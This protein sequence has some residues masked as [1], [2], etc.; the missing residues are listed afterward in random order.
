MDTE[1]Y[2]KLLAKHAPGRVANPRQIGLS[3]DEKQFVVWFPYDVDIIHDLK[4]H[5]PLRIWSKENHCWQVAAGTANLPHLI[6]LAEKWNFMFRRNAYEV[7]EQMLESIAVLSEGSAALDAEVNV[8]GWNPKYPLHTFQKA[9]VVYASRAQRCIIGDEMG[10]GKTPQALATLE[11]L[12]AYPAVVVCMSSVKYQWQDEVQKF[13]PGRT[14]EVISSKE[15]PTY[16]AD[17]EIINYDILKLPREWYDDKLR[18]PPAVRYNVDYF[19][20]LRGRQNQAIVFD[21]IHLAKSH[22]SQRG[23]ACL[24]LARDVPIKLGLTGTAIENRPAELLQPLKI[25]GRLEDMGGFWYFVNAWCNAEQTGYGLNI[26]GS[27]NLKTLNERLRACCYIRRDKRDVMTEIPRMQPVK[28]RVPIT[29]GAAYDRAESHFL[30]YLAEYEDDDGRDLVQQFA[31]MEKLRQLA[32]RGKLKAIEEWIRTFVHMDQKLIVF[33]HHREIQDVLWEISKKALTDYGN[34][35]GKNLRPTFL[36]AGDN[37]VQQK[38]KNFFQADPDC[39]I[40]VCSLA[41]GGTAHNLSSATNL[42]FC[43]LPWTPSGVDQAIARAY[44]RLDNIHGVDAYFAIGHKTIDEEQWAI[45]EEKREVT[46]QVI[47]GKDNEQSVVR[48]SQEELIA[49]FIRKAQEVRKA[50]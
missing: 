2:Q 35:I 30:S 11:K 13:L 4:Y 33:A 38:N 41:V 34:E 28:I 24:E 39:R 15:I 31:Q 17:I 27:K 5:L 3:F 21:E 25:L 20:H 50:A 32:A 43:E 45:I 8:P 42:L 16:S 29:N 37:Q 14:V 18:K 7:A 40:I 26:K 19:Q 6:E 22:K 46:S 23:E 44:G 9:G 1:R 49:R 10:L 48:A 47:R 12:D 36:F